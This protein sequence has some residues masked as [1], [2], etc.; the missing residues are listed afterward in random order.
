LKVTMSQT[1]APAVGIVAH[2]RKRSIVVLVSLVVSTSVLGCGGS[3]TNTRTN[4]ERESVVEL[5][6]PTTQR[7]VT[8][9][10]LH[11][12]GDKAAVPTEHLTPP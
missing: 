12:L 2:M 11:A 3:A 10:P 8:V 5:P 9:R 6:T 1:R 7:T 4:A